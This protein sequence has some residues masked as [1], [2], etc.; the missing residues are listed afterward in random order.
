LNQKLP[1]PKN[2][3]LGLTKEE[4]ILIE[5]EKPSEKED[6]IPTSS[7]SRPLKNMMKPLMSLLSS[8]T[9]LPLLL[10]DKEE[11]T[12]LKSRTLPQN[13]KHMLISSQ[14]KP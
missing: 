1:R 2:T 8:E 9:T 11:L 7:S 4:L 6:V 10:K 14:M 13:F 12:L 5:R 3:L